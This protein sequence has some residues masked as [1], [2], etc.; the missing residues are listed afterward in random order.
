MHT[1]KKEEQQKQ[2]QRIL[3]LWTIQSQNLTQQIKVSL[4]LKR[5][6]QFEKTTETEI[7]AYTQKLLF[8]LQTLSGG[9]EGH[10]KWWCWACK[11]NYIT[12]GEQK[13]TL[14]FQNYAPVCMQRNQWRGAPIEEDKLNYKV[15]K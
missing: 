2:N 3:M 1:Y 4:K 13:R 9:Y 7:H 12:G 10:M 6:S 5:K 8:N 14:V 11:Q 15:K